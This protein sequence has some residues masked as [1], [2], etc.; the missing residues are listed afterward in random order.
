MLHNKHTKEPQCHQ[1]TSQL[2]DEHQQHTLDCSCNLPGAPSWPDCR[3]ATLSDTFFGKGEVL[4]HPARKSRLDGAG[5]GLDTSGPKCAQK[6]PPPESLQTFAKPTRTHTH[7][8]TDPDK[9][10]DK[11]SKYRRRK[12]ESPI[13]HDAHDVIANIIRP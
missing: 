12:S 2:L 1:P 4:M 3:R 5:G 8:N 11:P 6:L 9:H 10:A 13:G 7:T